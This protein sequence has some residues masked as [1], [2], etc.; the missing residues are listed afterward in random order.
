P[1]E[2]KYLRK[3]HAVHFRCHDPEADGLRVDVMSRMRGVDTFEKLWTRRTTVELPD[4]AY[5]DLLSLPDVVQAKKTQ[6]D[7][8]WPMIRRLVEAD[9]F[10]RRESET[11]GDVR[12]WL[13]ELRTPELLV[14]VAA[15]HPWICRR[16][17]SKRPL[18]RLALRGDEHALVAALMAE[19]EKERE[20]DRQ[21]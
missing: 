2:A 1:F 9:Y 21:Y 14:V 19:E 18:L 13:R 3:G 16:L 5:F 6:R 8:D 11:A 7:K 12:F 20:A 15:A 4:G 10:G 17:A